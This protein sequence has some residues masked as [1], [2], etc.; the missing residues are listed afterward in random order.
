M[1]IQLITCLVLGTSFAAFAADDFSQ[2]DVDQNG[3]I[4]VEEAK[5]NVSLVHQFKN[6]DADKNGELSKDEFANFKSQ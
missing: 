1:K 5:A 6:L 4:S 3:S 2:Y